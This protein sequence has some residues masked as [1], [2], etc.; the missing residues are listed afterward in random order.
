MI[1]EHVNALLAGIA[2][3][4]ISGE[5]D[6]AMYNL[7]PYL[8]NKSPGP[9]IVAAYARLCVHYNEEEKAL[10]LIEDTLKNYD[11]N[12]Q[13][14]SSLHFH[15]GNLY[16]RVKEYD[17]AFIHFT[18]ANIIL[19]AQFNKQAYE[20]FIKAQQQ[21]FTN[22][23][24]SSFARADIDSITP[25]FIVG[26]PRSGTTLTEQIMDMHSQIHGAGELATINEM[27]SSL[28]QRFSLKQP[29]PYNLSELSAHHFNELARQYISV[30]KMDSEP[31]ACV[32]DK[33]PS[34][35]GHL[36]FIELIM[37][38]AKVIHCR[39]HP[40]DTCLSAYFQN[41]GNAHQY[42]RNLKHLAQMYRIYM[43][44][45]DM[46]D[47]ITSLP[48]KE[49]RYED[50]VREQEASSRNI[51]S[52]CNLEWEDACLAFNESKRDV[53]TCSYSQVRKPMYSTSIS[54]WK[55]YEK[56]IVP[57]ISELEDITEEYE[58]SVNN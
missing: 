49:L 58:S 21:V 44:M 42:S 13:L 11:M 14:E 25:I 7:L 4:E 45:V 5:F 22:E 26:M 30:A 3:L 52:F 28:H 57:L 53:K 10:A 34:N 41:F 18:E 46:W 54:K 8:Q 48:I 2:Q 43:S 37:P 56:H 33:M 1:T 29:Y 23:S 20:S 55:N 40:L 47:G 35:C 19:T 31:V 27:V 9:H 36:G 16:D 24:M 50:M 15:A 32:T 17:I 12:I 38:C 39:R 51:I 6:E